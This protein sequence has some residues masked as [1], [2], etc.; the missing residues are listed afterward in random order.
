ME[1]EQSHIA[2]ELGVEELEGP[3]Q[4]KTEPYS[5]V[6]MKGGGMDCS[7]ECHC[8]SG[9]KLKPVITGYLKKGKEV[10]E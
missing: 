5:R 7:V 6:Q 2:Q 8:V 4:K 1:E 3:Q 9:R 10:V